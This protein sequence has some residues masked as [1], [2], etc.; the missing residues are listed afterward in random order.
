[1]N[2]IITCWPRDIDVISPHLLTAKSTFHLGMAGNGLPIL[3]AWGLA[4]DLWQRH[5]P[6]AFMALSEFRTVFR[7][8]P[9]FFHREIASTVHGGT[10]LAT[11]AW[12]MT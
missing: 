11:T 7:Y 2:G 8:P 1:M 5:T 10:M 3:E 12:K 9:W 6:A 4:E